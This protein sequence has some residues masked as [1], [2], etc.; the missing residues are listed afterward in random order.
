MTRTTRHN[1]NGRRNGH[2]MKL[3]FDLDEKLKL[4]CED[5]IDT[6]SDKIIEFSYV[7]IDRL[8]KKYHMYYA[9]LNHLYTYNPVNS[10]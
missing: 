3:R 5:D 7:T 10:H 8:I 1:R 6:I 4:Q 9:A 2:L